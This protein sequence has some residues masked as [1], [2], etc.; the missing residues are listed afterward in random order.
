MS[1]VNL[2]KRIIEEHTL[3]PPVGAALSHKPNPSE[4]YQQ[5]VLDAL[6]D[7]GEALAAAYPILERIAQGLAVAAILAERTPE[8]SGATGERLEEPTA[9]GRSA[10]SR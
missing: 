6:S 5:R 8:E 1:C 7:A 2:A 9:A 3:T 4:L 10:A